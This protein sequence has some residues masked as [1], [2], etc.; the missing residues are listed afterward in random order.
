MFAA[1]AFIITVVV[2]LGG[3][4]P[5]V[6]AQAVNGITKILGDLFGGEQEEE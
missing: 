4:L 5:G 2:C 3:G 1:L 6:L